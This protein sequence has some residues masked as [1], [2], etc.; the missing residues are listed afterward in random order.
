MVTEYKTKDSITMVKNPNY[1]GGA[2]YL[3]GIKFVNSIADA[4]GDSTYNALST[5][6]FNMAFLRDPAAVANAHDKKFD[7]VSTMEQAGGLLLINQ[8]NSVTC[9]GGNPAPTCTGKP[10]GV[11]VSNPP[12]KDPKVRQAIAAA[13][14]PKVINDRGY[15]GKGL[16]GNQLFQS[17]FR[18][19]P[20]VAGPKF[21]VELAKR[22]V[23]EAKTAGLGRSSAPALQQLPHCRRHR[24]R[25]A[26]DVAE[27]R[28]DRRP[29]H[30]QGHQRANRS[31]GRAQGL[32]RHRL[33]YGHPSR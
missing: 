5:G 11:L 18:W 25:S 20:D 19:F 3:D 4:G 12:T 17:D 33:G 13:I 23:T 16:V 30:R 21:D 26:D 8:G 14:D 29:R 24:A 7:D 1:F 15:Q 27:R 28:H 10:D 31:G 9:T 2:P 22:L 6:T 32:R